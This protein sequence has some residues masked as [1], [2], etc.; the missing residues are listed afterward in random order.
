MTI[1]DLLNTE[2]YARIRR[3]TYPIPFKLEMNTNITDRNDSFLL[4]LY[5]DLYVDLK[6]RLKVD[7]SLLDFNLTRLRFCVDQV[8]TH[9]HLEQT[10]LHLNE[11]ACALE[12]YLQ[13]D[14]LLIFVFFILIAQ[15]II[16]YSSRFIL[17]KNMFI[18]WCQTT[19]FRKTLL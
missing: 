12:F 5:Q 4:R 3:N 6:Q 18:Q 17:F 11:L 16:I 9:Y 19:S 1:V 15:H 7:I 2:Q 13:I 14:G 10:M 8:V